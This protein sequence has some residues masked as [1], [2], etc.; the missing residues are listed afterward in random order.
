M[1]KP[2]TCLDGPRPPKLDP[3][4]VAPETGRVPVRLALCRACDS[5]I[6]QGEVVCPHCGGDVP[7]AAAA[8]EAD[9]LRRAALIADV[10]RH[11]DLIERSAA[12]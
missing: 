4:L 8:H 5:Y 3:A 1:C 6:N 11:L 9:R 7:A 12:G 2:L 10:E